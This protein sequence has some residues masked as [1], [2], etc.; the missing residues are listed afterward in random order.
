[1][2]A[3]NTALYKAAQDLW[4]HVFG[5]ERGLLA[6]CHTEG[7]NFRT[8]YFNYPTAAD[9]AAEWILEKAEEGHEVYFCAHLLTEP[10][11]VKGNATQVHALWGD[12]DGTAVP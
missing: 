6:I 2:S 1:M 11:R 4:H 5:E 12:L 8:Q 10:R 9:S 3:S 7:A